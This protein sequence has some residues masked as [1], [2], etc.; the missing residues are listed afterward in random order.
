MNWKV[1]PLETMVHKGDVLW[2]D[3]PQVLSVLTGQNLFK[4]EDVLSKMIEWTDEYCKSPN[5]S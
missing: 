3:G 5:T 4:F 2:Y 1:N